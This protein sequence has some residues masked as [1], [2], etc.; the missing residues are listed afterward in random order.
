M[1]QKSFKVL[2]LGADSADYLNILTLNGLKEFPNLDLYTYPEPN[3][4]YKEKRDVYENSLR[5][6][7]F[8]IF[9]LNEEGNNSTPHYLFDLIESS[10]FDLIIFGDIF[11]YYPLYLWLDKFNSNKNL[12]IVILDGSDQE[13]LFPYSGFFYRKLSHFFL[14]RVLKRHLY[15]KRELTQGSQKSRFYNLLP[16]FIANIIPMHKNL[17]EISFS[18]PGSK[19]IN[20][21]TLKK[22]KLF[23]NHIVD[24][25]VQL[26]VKET[27]SGYL[28]DTEEAYY[29]DI[30]NSKYGITTKRSGWDCLRHYEI[31]ANGAVMCFKD[32]DLKPPRCA[33]HDLV[34]GHNCLSYKS[35]E[36]L[37]AQIESIDEEKYKKILNGSYEWILSKA[38]KKVT[39]KMLFESGI[40]F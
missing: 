16:S 6:K 27:S 28:F 38:S 21:N 1:Q 39:K 19:I 2:F 26:K 9:F 23:M 40:E 14:P 32:L 33:P 10:S 8:S 4:L 11:Y 24:E 12:N 29:S 22:T 20:P 34:P 18:F 35:Y 30:Q 37:K 3:L 36:D 17:R 13:N 5:G 25:E 15:F 31:A 7:G